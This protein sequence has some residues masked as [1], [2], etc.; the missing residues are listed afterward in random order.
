MKI[1]IFSDIHGNGPAFD[2]AYDRILSEKADLNVFLGDL[3]GYYY[4]QLDIL[5]MLRMMPNFIAVLGNH[6]RIFLDIVMGDN[7]L[8]NRYC[9]EYG[10]SME[11]LLE[12]DYSDLTTWLGSLQEYHR[13][14]DGK[15]S[16]FH[17]SPQSYLEGYVYPDSKI[18]FHPESHGKCMFLGNTH[19]KM[20]KSINGTLIVNP[21]SLGQPRDG[22]WPSYAVV[23][24]PSCKVQFK[25]IVYDKADLKRKIREAGEENKFS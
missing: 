10:I 7:V 23:E 17:G 25:E 15:F 3:C 4:D 9:Q 18:N 14:S 11:N 1:C 8:R 16:C 19:Y 20:H 2:V 24:F 13:D 22:K 12:L 6:D 5:C 21:G